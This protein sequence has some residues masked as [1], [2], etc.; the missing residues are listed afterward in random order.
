MTVAANAARAKTPVGFFS[1]ELGA[2]EVAQL[3]AAQRSNVPRAVL[4]RGRADGEYGERLKKVLQDDG[5]MP[6]DILDD[7][8]WP[9]GLTREGFGQLVA[10]GVKRFGWRLIVLDYLGLLVPP[11]EDR[12]QFDTDV[13]TSTA[14]RKLARKHDIAFLVVT[15]QRKGATYR[16]PE[17]TTIDDIAGAGR[18]VYDAQT[19]GVV[20]RKHGDDDTGLVYFRPLKVRFA[21]TRE[22]V[23]MQF[24][25]FP[26][27]GRI[28]NLT[29]KGEREG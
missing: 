11:K 18:L 9:G 20:S 26:K 22:D 6:L 5:D 4:A 8:R 1:L 12:D 10:D 15:H 27:T 24:R 25:W 21:R 13:R 19:V 16:S 14:L 3:V 7:E 23:M 29:S 28:E 2:D 17:A